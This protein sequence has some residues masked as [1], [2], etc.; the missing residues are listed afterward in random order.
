[1]NNFFHI[2]Y[3]KG[4]VSFVVLFFLGKVYFFEYMGGLFEGDF[5]EPCNGSPKITFGVFYE[6][7]E[8]VEVGLLVFHK[9][10]SKNCFYFINDHAVEII[11]TYFLPYKCLK[12]GD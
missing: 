2:R 10:N 4:Y 12:G 6:I 5:L 11:N 1:M 7:P 3:D 8:I 9:A